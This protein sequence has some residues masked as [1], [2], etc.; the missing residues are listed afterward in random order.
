MPEPIKVDIPHNLGRETAKSRMTGGVGKLADM[1]PGG[2]T[3]QHRWEG[4]T[5][6]FTLTAMG[7]TVA[8]RI[9]VFDNKI[10]AEVDLPP[11]LALFGG[12]VRD[13]LMQVAPKLLK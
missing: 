1:V 4:D 7:Q 13:K 8:S 2:G 12:K 10:H 9:D 6:H 3:V 11:M 5:L